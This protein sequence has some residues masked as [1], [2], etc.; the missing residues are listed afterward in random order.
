[1]SDLSKDSPGEVS[2]LMGNEAIARGAIEAGVAF[3]S[4]YPGNPSSEII[5]VLGSL[6]KELGIYV[7]WSTNEKVA[8]EAAAGA[9]YAGLRSICAMK[10]NGLNVASDFISNVV[11]TGVGP[12][13]MVLIVAD[14]PGG[15]SSS[16]EEDTRYFSRLLEI[17]LLEPAGF[18]EA[19]DMTKFAFRLSEE[20]GLMVMIR[21]V[22]RISH[23]RGNVVYSEIEKANKKARFD[24]NRSVLAFP[25]PWTH[26]I[27][28]DK[29]ARIKDKFEE[30]DFN[31]YEGP[32]GAELIVAASGAAYL[33]TKEALNLLDLSGKVGI[34]KLGTTFPLP[35]DFIARN[36]KG[37]KK[38][39]V[40][41]E[42]IP[43]IEASVKEAYANHVK[44]LGVI[45][46]YGKASG[47]LPRENELSP[48]IMAQAIA[49]L[50]GKSYVPVDPDY[51]S[52]IMALAL[53]NSPYRA[54]TFC[55][56]C[57]HRATYWDLKK[58]LKLDGRDGFIV[59]DIGC[60]TIG[61]GPQGYSMLRTTHAM[62]SGSGLATGLGQLKAFGLDQPV[63]AVSGD[64]TF[65]HSVIPA[66]IN[67][68]H[69]E[70]NFTMV[71]LDN[72]TT[73]MTGAQPHPG[74]EI[75]AMGAPAHGLSIE[76]ICQSL[77]AKVRV[78]DPFNVEETV[79]SVYDTIQDEEGIKVVIMRQECCLYRLKKDD[80]RYEVRVDQKRCLGDAC[81]C[82]RLCT[83]VFKCPG[84][85]WDRTNKVA[86]IDEVICNGCGVCAD[87]CPEGAIIREVTHEA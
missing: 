2:L 72:S 15:I 59:G 68:A 73:A 31:R 39:L 80:K 78:L 12:G 18:Q 76:K 13:G 57:P 4:A 45:E 14:D 63:L 48:D 27:L 21:S 87:I 34:L 44:D 10:Q 40:A 85:I 81:G 33:Y 86:L 49:G 66:L 30:S 64:S 25:V 61:L 46:F 71:V 83:R 75:S 52:K 17:P 74:S 1:M 24:T 29:M 35:D 51:Q 77:G 11:L 56:G 6:A 32:K 23:G 9:S 58:A 65:Y 84:I 16:N 47:N 20:T 60:Y 82:N 42:V 41:E 62:G 79:Q 7:E 8:I 3:A 26:K 38:V 70:S 28:H 22:T 50:M 19:K 36:L 69:H 37:V 5:T 55:A 54:L 53:P 67:A 43:F